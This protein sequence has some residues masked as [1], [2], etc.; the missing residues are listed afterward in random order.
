MRLSFSIAVAIAVSITFVHAAPVIPLTEVRSKAAQGLRLLELAED[1]DPVWKT[2]DEKVDLIKAGVHFIDITDTYEIDQTLLKYP[3]RVS[4]FRFADPTHQAEVNPILSTIS[5]P[6]MQSNLEKLSGFNN[7]YYRSSTGGEASKWILSTVQAIAE[8]KGHISAN[9]FSHPSWPQTST[10]VHIAGKDNSGPVTILGAHMDSVNQRNPSN[11]RS[12]GADDDGSGSVN[13]IEAFRA[14]V[15]SGFE[16][17]NPVEFHWYAAEEGGLLG[18]RAI[19]SK[20]KSDGVNVKGYM[21]LDMTAY[22]K[23]GDKEVVALMTDNTDAA[24]NDYVE[25]LVTTYTRLA[26]ARSK[27]GYG[28]SDHASWNRYGYPA[29]MPFE[30][31]MG[32]DNP[33]IH[34]D[35]DTT[36]APGFSWDHSLEFTKL[37]VSFAYELSA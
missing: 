29:T 31:P 23:P 3:L 1:A 30:T 12:P 25:K 37:A 35:K 21:N 36:S 26:V 17:A 20:Y 24:L 16:P 18:S 6:N 32:S 11:G 2:E 33:T 15:D 7:R 8:G 22:F 27:C 14:L 19:A 10:I 13:L 5:V 9:A 28:C 34:T 4:P